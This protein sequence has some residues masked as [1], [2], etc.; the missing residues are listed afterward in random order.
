MKNKKRINL[1]WIKRDIRTQDHAALE[2]AEQ[3]R[4]PYLIIY[5]FEPSLLAYPDSSLRHH[6]FIYHSLIDA[7]KKLKAYHRSIQIFYVEAPT[8]FKFILQHFDLKSV[9]SYQ[10]SGIKETWNR[11]KK[12]M[13]ILKK[14]IFL[15]ISF[16]KV[17]LLEELTIE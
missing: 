8:F 15:G 16:K 12:V 13:N 7:N 1:V 5:L 17:E 14:M 2:A 4:I 11:D 3:S 10:E 9:F 6:Q